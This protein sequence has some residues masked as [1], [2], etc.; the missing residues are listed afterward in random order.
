M[1]GDNFSCD[2]ATLYE[3]VSVSWSVGPS[4]RQSVTLLL[5]GLLRATYGRVSGLV[6]TLFP[7][8]SGSLYY[9][10]SFSLNHPQEGNIGISGSANSAVVQQTSMEGTPQP[11]QK[12]V[13]NHSGTVWPKLCG[14]NQC[15]K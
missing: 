9:D 3:R 12:T 4:V 5:F 14:S 10:Y 2:E 1:R 11:L 7:I 8:P 13:R 6:S 15:G